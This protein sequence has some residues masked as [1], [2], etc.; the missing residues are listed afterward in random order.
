MSYYETYEPVVTWFAVR[1]MIIFGILFQWLL[2]QVDLIMAYPQVP[3]KMN[4]YMEL[5]QGIETAEGNSEDHVL[6]LLKNIYGQKQA[7]RLWNE[8]LIDRLNSIGF[9]NP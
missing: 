9:T 4:I 7:G 6:K 3:I 2:Q 8:Y 5:P 1:L